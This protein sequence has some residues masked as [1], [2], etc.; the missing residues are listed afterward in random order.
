MH[1][2]DWA[3]KE[4]ETLSHGLGVALSCGIDEYFDMPN[5]QPVLTERESILCVSR[6]LSSVV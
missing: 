4:K 2:R 1:L 3:Q 6:M 5:T